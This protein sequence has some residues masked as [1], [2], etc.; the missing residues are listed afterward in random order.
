MENFREAIKAPT[1]EEKIKAMEDMFCRVVM[2]SF[3]LSQ[4]DQEEC[5]EG[6]KE[7]LSEEEA[8]VT[9]ELLKRLR[10]LIELPSKSIGLK[11]RIFE[12][13]D[14]NNNAINNKENLYKFVMTGVK[15]Y[16]ENNRKKPATTWNLQIEKIMKRI[17]EQDK[18]KQN[19]ESIKEM[20]N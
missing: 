14:I 8:T 18:K 11:K 2:C 1:K 9:Y 19:E 13:L 12:F 6:S 17:E 15:D 4:A 3:L 10:L 20:E 5:I 7:V 16:E